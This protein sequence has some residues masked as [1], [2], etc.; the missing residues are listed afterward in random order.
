MKIFSF[1]SLLL[2]GSLIALT[3]PAQ[4]TNDL[5]ELIPPYAALPPSLWEQ[6]GLALIFCFL[7]SAAAGG[8]L[9]WV[10]TRPRP[11]PVVPAEVQARQAL[12]ILRA[13][14]QTGAVIS[15]VSQVLR[16]YISSAFA[17]PAGELTTQELIAA[18]KSARTFDNKLRETAIQFLE[19]C[20]E[21]KFAPTQVA[22]PQNVASL[23]LALI[24]QGESVRAAQMTTGTI[25]RA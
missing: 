9:I 7:I 10:L 2:S 4:S 25:T 3:L 16:R 13:Q 15:Q 21:R 14:P 19:S 12:A 24:E 18:M 11:A 23:A 22:P 17:L 1:R 8:V 20:D 6:Y 5:P